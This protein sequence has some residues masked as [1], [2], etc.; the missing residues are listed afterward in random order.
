MKFF[1]SRLEQERNDKEG[2][3]ETGWA[4]VSGSM[5]DRMIAIL[6]LIL[7]Q[8]GVGLGGQVRRARQ[9]P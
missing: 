3:F 7:A 2:V 4:G 5:D 1:S 9:A 6:R 8:D